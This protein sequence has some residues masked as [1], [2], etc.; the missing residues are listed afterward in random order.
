M[1]EA[2]E[3]LYHG[4]IGAA[5]EPLTHNLSIGS[6]PLYL[7]GAIAAYIFLLYLYPNGYK[8]MKKERLIYSLCCPFTDEIHYI[9]KTTN[10]MRR[11]LEHSRKSHSEKVI[12]WVKNL[13]D[14]GHSP[15]IKILECVSNDDNIDIKERFWIKHYLSKGALLLNDNLVSPL[16]LD[17]ELDK[18]LDNG[19]G[20]EMEKISKFI[21]IK[22]KSVNIDQ[23][24]FARKSGVS[25][26][27][28]RKIEQGKINFQFGGLLKILNMFGCTLE[29][30]KLQKSG[31]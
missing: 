7:L 22:R 19:E 1:R 11:P 3:P 31:T 20:M 26:K 28:L 4:E 25:L 10:G 16:L 12:E 6:A 18:I 13:K 15:V 14:I 24:E 21:K 23:P 8:F 2:K 9:G 29:I 5:S 30:T 17:K 27:V